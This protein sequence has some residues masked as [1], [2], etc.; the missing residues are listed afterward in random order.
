M[1]VKVEFFFGG[2][3]NVRVVHWGVADVL[4]VGCRFVNT[5]MLSGPATGR[6][7]SVKERCD[8]CTATSDIIHTQ[9]E[10]VASRRDFIHTQQQEILYTRSTKGYHTHTAKRDMIHTQE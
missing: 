1:G 8:T 9:K 4:V 2:T 10:G 3:D 7:S 6:R 5:A